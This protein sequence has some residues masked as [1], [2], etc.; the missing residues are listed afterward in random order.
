[1][2]GP[3]N[4]AHRAV[5]IVGLPPERRLGIG[6]RTVLYP[7]AA[8]VA[9]TILV[10]VVLGCFPAINFEPF[11]YLIPVVICAARW[12]L[13]AALTC[14]IASSLVSDFLFLQPLYSFEI[15]DHNQIVEM[16]I[17]LFVALVTSKLAAQLKTEVDAARRHEHEIRNLYEFTRRLGQCS[18]IDDLIAAIQ[19]YLSVHLGCEACLVGAASRFEPPAR[20]CASATV[21]DPI[22]REARKMIAA[23]DTNS[24]LAVEEASQSLWVLKAI[25][26]KMATHGALAVNLGNHSEPDATRLHNRID[27]LLSEASAALTRIDAMAALA[28]ADVRLEADIL[29]TALIGTASHELRSPVAA[30]L[31]SVSVLDQ[32]PAFRTNAKLRSLV[33]GMRREANRL[34]HDIQNLLD[35]ARITDTGVTPRFLWTDP[36]DILGAAIRQR[37]DRVAADRFKLDIDPGL[38][39]LNIDPILIEQAVGQIIENAAKYSPADTDI[40]VVARAEDGHILLSVTDLGVGLTEEEA[41]HLFR[42]AM[43]G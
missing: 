18:T 15:T 11:L 21:P 24:R 41:G 4:T 40:R 31:G 6:T 13:A 27:A 25:A 29:K 7:L 19:E 39:L 5:K 16:A 38:P 34:D 43:R 8:V 32:M 20:C 22:A 14:I 12:G 33:A 28:N 2:G 37:S 26:T 10:F 17:F 23:G 1:M 42:R 35:T 30:I 36:A 3:T 9:T